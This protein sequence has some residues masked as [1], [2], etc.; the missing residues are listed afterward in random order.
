MTVLKRILHRGA[1]LAESAWDRR[2]FRR[3]T[4][5]PYIDPFIGYS[6]PDHIVARGRVLDGKPVAENVAPDSSLWS[7]F[8]NM[9][10][11]FITHEV[12]GV[13]IRIGNVRDVADEE[14]YFHIDLPRPAD[15]AVSVEASLTGYD[16][17]VL[18]PIIVT[19]PAARFGIISDIDDT[20][21]RTDA[22]SLW[23]NLFNT[24]TG[25]VASRQVFPDAKTLLE[26][27]H[28]GVNPVFYVSSS[29]WNL[30][31]FLVRVFERNGLVPGPLFLRD[32]G[33]SRT[34]FIKGSHGEHKGK[35]IDKILAAN[36]DLSFVLIGDTGQHDPEV[37][38]AAIERH[39]G[40]FTEAWFRIPRE[41]LAPRYREWIERIRDAGIATH[42][43]TDFGVG[44]TIPSQREPARNALGDIP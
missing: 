21:I 28:A 6:A 15:G 26:R 32:L 22:W 41:G 35:M 30:H 14:G 40:R 44:G 9:I 3:E 18:L 2:P 4:S 11:R 23:R 29:P 34:K 1:V 33:I 36:P 19:D 24:L 13:E 38:H 42:A 20:L 25:N 27:L 43:T 16:C 31:A 17:K 39:P 10:K 7:N 8:R 5:S 12:P 37:Y